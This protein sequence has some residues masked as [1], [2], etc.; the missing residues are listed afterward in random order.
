MDPYSAD[1]Q[2]PIGSRNDG[3]REGLEEALW[4]HITGDAVVVTTACS[5]PRRS[6]VVIGFAPRRAREGLGGIEGGLVVCYSSLYLV[7]LSLRT[8][9][10]GPCSQNR[11][12][13]N[14]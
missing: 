12:C 11:S 13:C 2:G 1:G 14:Q 4:L 8:S 7:F 9:N 5:W 10:R 3:W 6:Y